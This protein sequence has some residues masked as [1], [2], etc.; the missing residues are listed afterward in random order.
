MRY[1]WLLLLI[2]AS[3]SL[4]ASYYYRFS[5]NGKVIIK[6]HIPAE[7]APLGYEVLNANGSLVEVVPRQLTPEE[8]HERER[9]K[10]QLK[11]H[12]QR[13]ALQREEDMKLLRAYA[14]DRDIV[15]FF[16]RK[17]EDLAI[18]I[19]H[20]RL[21]L[22]ERYSRLAELERR[23][24]DYEQQDMT[25][26]HHI[27]QDID[28][29]RALVSIGEQRIQAKERDLVNLELDYKAVRY[30]F[31]VLQHY[32]AGVLPEEIDQSKLNLSQ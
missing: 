17:K 18:S 9:K 2:I 12:E 31:M 5:L 27:V 3:Q 14:N 15:R 8:I 24:A 25:V 20:Q 32:P 1:I 4:A 6:D 23:Q 10:A 7:Y 30:R 16:E 21:N 29:N 26:P 11:Q 28:N 19:Q 22:S 13:V